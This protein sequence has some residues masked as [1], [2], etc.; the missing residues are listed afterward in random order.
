M[1]WG[2]CC[3]Y[4]VLPKFLQWKFVWNREVRFGMEAFGCPVLPYFP[5]TSYYYYYYLRGTIGKKGTNFSININVNLKK[6]KIGRK[7]RHFHVNVLLHGHICHISFFLMRF[8]LFGYTHGRNTSVFMVM[9]F[10]PYYLI[11]VRLRAMWSKRSPGEERLHAQD[12]LPRTCTRP[13]VLEECIFFYRAEW[14]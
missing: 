8:L 4:T 6:T 13:H 2:T 14:P 3:P 1:G 9:I 12:G 5:V 11:V 7:Y 10:R